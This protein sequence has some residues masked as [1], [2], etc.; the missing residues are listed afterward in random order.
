M[1]TCDDPT[2]L[3]PSLVA[4]RLVLS[5]HTLD[6]FE[7]CAAMWG[8]PAVTRH[9]GGQ[10]SSR[11]D[12]WSRLLRYAG[13]WSLMGFGYWA[14][15]EKSSGRFAGEIGFADFKRDIQP[16]FGGAPEIGWALAPWAQ[17]KGFATEAVRAAIAWGDAKFERA[18]TVCLIAPDN[19]P[20][21]RV[22][23]KTGYREFVRTTYKTKPTILFERFPA[24][25]TGNFAAERSEIEFSA[26]REISRE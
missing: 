9:I 19:L 15:R 6:D 20:S 11:E 22:A 14:I 12:V 3:V 13:H 1:P 16:S 25:G 10:P 17:G 24:Y 7:A 2:G 26:S 8:N 4:E 18:R 5:R 21:L 23:E